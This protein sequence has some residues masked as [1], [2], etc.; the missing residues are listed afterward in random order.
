MKRY[1]NALLLITILLSACN[2][3]IENVTISYTKGTAIYA[4][5]DQIRQT[6]LSASVRPVENA[7]KIFIS[8]N[9]LLIGEEGEGIHIFNNSDPQNPVG[10]SFMSIP[11]NKE[12]Y[13]D[14][15]FL[16]AESY[17][18]MLKIDLTNPAQPQMVTR[19]ENAI[20]YP[21]YNGIGE[22]IIGFEFEEVTEK[23]DKDGDVY[24]HL[25]NNS[26]ELYFDYEQ[27][28][29]PESAVPSSFAGNS[30][31]QIGSVNRIASLDGNLY[32]ISRSN[33]SVYTV[34]NFEQVYHQSVGW[35]M[36]TVYPF[37]DR[38]FIGTNSSVDIYNVSD[39]SNPHI[40]S[41]FW[42]ATS[43]D[44]V[45]PVNERTAYATLRTGEFV[46]CPG[47]VNE[48]VVLDV[49]VPDFAQQV[50]GI[51]MISPYGLT[52][53]N[54]TLYVGEGSNGLKV[55]DASNERNLK[56]LK[57]DQTVDAYDVLAHPT[58]S[59]ILLIA[60]PDG[61]SQY[62]IGTEEFQLVSRIAF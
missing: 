52:M 33:L 10:Q 5:L 53:I 15:N 29:I 26:S 25:W 42:H 55:F 1:C 60:G 3:D 13:V 27:N 4:N 19:I 58:L 18:D 44:P 59:H 24:N 31:N 50:Q 40:E 34:D 32:V 28:L 38:L 12:F 6:D 16:F 47:D 39:P 41:S 22:V 56:L 20:S 43:C 51:E 21:L 14:G 35:N 37:G 9:L 45:Y 8:N 17:Y 2:S 7:G 54:E 23:V 48:L 30:S 49:S 62:Q 11:G 61:L 36:E 46:E 57:W